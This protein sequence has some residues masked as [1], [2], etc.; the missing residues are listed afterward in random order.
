MTTVGTVS[1]HHNLPKGLQTEAFEGQEKGLYIFHLY[2]SSE[3]RRDGSSKDRGNILKRT[4]PDEADGVVWDLHVHARDW[5]QRQRT[6]EAN[7]LSLHNLGTYLTFDAI[8]YQGLARG[9]EFTVFL[10]HINSDS[11]L[12]DY[13]AL[14]ISEV[15]SLQVKIAD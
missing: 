8:T 7:A 15:C 6:S 3:M 13:D 11:I 12:F 4:T 9:H 5:S 14:Q 10:D 1:S 2:R